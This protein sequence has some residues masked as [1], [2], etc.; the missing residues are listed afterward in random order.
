MLKS[1][2]EIKGNNFTF[3]VLHLK[4]ESIEKIKLALQKKINQA[5]KFFLYAPVILDISLLPSTV[6]WSSICKVIK[7]LQLQ[8]IAFMK[9][10]NSIL[11]KKFY[12][13]GIP[14]LF[15][16]KKEKNYVKY[17][18]LYKKNV[19]QSLENISFIVTKPVRSGQKIYKSNRDIIIINSVSEGAEILSDRNIHVYGPLRG[20]VLAGINGDKNCRIFCTKLFAE[21]ISICGRFMLMD[22]IPSHFIGKPVQFYLNN[23][24]LKILK[25]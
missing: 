18:N 20:K 10:N 6:N 15:E 13:Q 11:D 7:S 9:S 24:I 8:V 22:Q 23:G 25:M 12:E 3:L 21:L 14:I 5:P 2:I 17:E 4:T 16:K 1:V 19:N